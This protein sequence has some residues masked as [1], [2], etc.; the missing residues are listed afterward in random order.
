MIQQAISLFSILKKSQSISVTIR[1]T[2]MI[3]VRLNKIE[4]NMFLIF[5]YLNYTL[6]DIT[7]SNH[8]ERHFCNT[9]Y[10]IYE[11]LQS[12]L[13]VSV[14]TT[15][16]GTIHT[17][18]LVNFSAL[19]A[20]RE[21]SEMFGIF[22]ENHPDLRKLLLDYGAIGAPLLKQFPLPGYT[23]I[24][25]TVKKGLVFT[26]IELPQILRIFQYER[27]WLDLTPLT[28]IEFPDEESPIEEIEEAKKAAAE[29]AKR[30]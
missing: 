9:V 19:V 5:K 18:S 6:I 13:Y 21:C 16:H 22:F 26:Q 17:A 4:P 15:D 10:Y 12:S 29:A 20:E 14:L 11:G 23:Q 8:P 2:P 3:A 25:Y 30:P 24:S 27:P 1:N 7:A 28:N